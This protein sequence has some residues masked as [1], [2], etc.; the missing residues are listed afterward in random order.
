MHNILIGVAT[1][2][3]LGINDAFQHKEAITYSTYSG[4]IWENEEGKAGGRKIN[5]G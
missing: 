3:V 4:D 2:A 1:E 5:D